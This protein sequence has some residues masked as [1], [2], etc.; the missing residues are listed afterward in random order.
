M[1]FIHGFKSSWK[2]DALSE[3]WQSILRLNEHSIFCLID[4]NEGYNENRGSMLRPTYRT[5]R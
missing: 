5:S 3:P 4:R 2:Q 1:G